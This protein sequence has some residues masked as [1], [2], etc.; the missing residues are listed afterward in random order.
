MYM[1]DLSGAS[2]RINGFMKNEYVLW[3]RIFF[4]N[5][6]SSYNTELSVINATHL[7]LTQSQV[8]EIQGHMYH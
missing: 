4:L 1:Y 6:R 5:G 7:I 2:V 3:G 8:L